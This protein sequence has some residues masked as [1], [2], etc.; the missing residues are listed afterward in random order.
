[1]LPLVIANLIISLFVVTNHFLNPVDDSDPLATSLTVTT[2][3]WLERL[4][5]NFN[6]HAEHHLL[7]HMSPR[8]APQIAELL[9]ELW[10]ERYH[11]MPHG[12]ALRAVWRTPR[13][14]YDQ[15]HLVDL[16]E[17]T[18]YGTLGHGLG[19]KNRNS[20]HS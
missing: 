20:F 5:L 11:Q 16:R 8:Y 17:K 4:F 14:Y 18:L 7:P 6:Y 2:Y 19:E 3:P 13:V 15:I 12:Q 1:L 9:K 10:P